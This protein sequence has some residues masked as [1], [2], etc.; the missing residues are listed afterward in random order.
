MYLIIDLEVVIIHWTIFIVEIID[1]DLIDNTP[2]LMGCRSAQCLM[3]AAA[4]EESLRISSHIIT[5]NC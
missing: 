1:L 5:F 3:L 2:E 4:T